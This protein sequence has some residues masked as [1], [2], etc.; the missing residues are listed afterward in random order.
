MTLQ[1]DKE[2]TQIDEAKRE[3][4]EI[5]G[6][7]KNEIKHEL[8]YDF[9]KKPIG[10]CFCIQGKNKDDKLNINK[11]IDFKELS[12][13]PLVFKYCEFK[14]IFYCESLKVCNVLSFQKCD[15]KG[16]ISFK[17]CKF[18][19]NIYFFDSDFFSTIY[20]HNNI[21]YKPAYFNSSDFL[22]N[23]SF[24]ENEFKDMVVFSY[25]AFHKNEGSQVL[26]SKSKFLGEVYFD[27]T[28]FKNFVDFHENKFE[29]IVCFYNATFEKVPN[30]SAC[31]FKEQKAVNLI[32]INTDKLDF[33]SL[34]RYIEDN[35]INGEIKQKLKYAKNAKD[36]FRVIKD[37]L[38]EQNNTLEAQE[39][40][41]LELYAK[42]LE[43]EIQTEITHTKNNKIDDETEV[44][45]RILSINKT[46]LWLY[47]NTSFHHT[48]I[49]RICNFTIFSIALYGLFLFILQKILSWFNLDRHSLYWFSWNITIIAILALMLCIKYNFKIKAYINMYL[50][51][52]LIFAGISCFLSGTILMPLG[53]VLF[54][55]AVYCLCLVFLIPFYLRLKNSGFSFAFYCVIYAIFVNVIVA[56]P[57][58]INPFIG[59]FGSDKLFN[60]SKFEQKLNGLDANTIINLAKI[61]QKD[62]DLQENYDISFTELNSAR[63]L[64]MQNK[65]ELY[66]ILSKVL[67]KKYLCDFQMILNILENDPSNLSNLIKNIDIRNKT[68]SFF[69]IMKAFLNLDFDKTSDINYDALATSFLS[70]QPQNQDYETFNSKE[71]QDK[72]TKILSLIKLDENSTLTEIKNAINYD[73][74]LSGAIK[75]TSV[76]YSIILLLCIFSL[77]KTVRKN[78]IVPS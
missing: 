7:D 22:E 46:L 17:N 59:V 38:I 57:Q 30:F 47:R 44:N 10:K 69:F 62:F 33:Y 24:V 31:Y 13:Y 11:Q 25:S 63:T 76:I 42:E 29:N 68:Y 6:I 14:K 2:L 23:F 74:I 4:A 20:F 3:I 53:S 43:L 73:E 64:I 49:I 52:I 41:K 71:N 54:F 36:S 56:K 78:S 40:H 50:V 65:A 27:D 32:N 77:Q 12:N 66:Q 72:L 9:E 16:E 55:F 67:D 19:E 26:F 18:K 28:T 37:I 51:I 39:W 1:E 34:E 35:C 15:F 21:F 48:H 60:E 8:S 75:S 61:S 45:F 70:I 58:L 5:L